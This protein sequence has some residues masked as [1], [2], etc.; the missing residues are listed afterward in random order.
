MRDKNMSLQEQ[1]GSFL[2]TTIKNSDSDSII[3]EFQ[4]RGEYVVALIKSVAS[5]KT[6]YQQ[7]ELAASLALDVL[8]RE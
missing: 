8:G 6:I 5:L 7:A 3:P 4:W 1:S 2:K